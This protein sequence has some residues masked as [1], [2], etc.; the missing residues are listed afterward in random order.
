MFPMPLAPDTALAVAPDVLGSLAAMSVGVIVLGHDLR[1]SVWNRWVESHS[2]IAE[3]EALGR[4]LETLFPEVRD[5]YFL[6]AVHGAVNGGYP[7]VLAP[8]LHAPVFPFFVAPGVDTERMRQQIHVIPLAGGSGC[9]VQIIDA[10]AAWHRESTLKRKHV[11]L[12]ESLELQERLLQQ[13]EGNK[14]ELQQQVRER[15]AQLEELAGQ[16]QDLSEHERAQLAR[17]LHDELGALMTA[18]RIDVTR[19]T[20]Q[21]EAS[22]ERRERALKNIDQAIQ[23]KRRIMEGMRPTLLDNFGVVVAIRELAREK[24]AVNSWRFHIDLPD[25]EMPIPEQLSITLY[26]VCQEALTN[27]A[28]YAEATELRLS[29]RAGKGVLVL[30]IIDNGVGMPAARDA[31]QGGHGISGMQHR[32]LARGGTLE[33]GSAEPHGTRVLARIPF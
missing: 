25:E 1:V 30:E 23:I 12:E 15:T 21:S 2:G 3:S 10:N 11:L 28:K 20:S 14:T 31:R 9:L 22:I 6:G 13:L 17:E 7:S 24:A 18:I 32:V 29:L 19:L 16:V 4:S 33:I 5:S 8:S 26:R 27:A